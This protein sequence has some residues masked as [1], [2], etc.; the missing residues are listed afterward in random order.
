V[1]TFK[2]VFGSIFNYEGNRAIIFQ[3][4]EQVPINEVKECIKAT[5][6]YHKVKRLPYLVSARKVAKIKIVLF[7]SNVEQTIA[8]YYCDIF[9]V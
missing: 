2:E 7:F 3:V 4:D 1:E 8:G 6:F 9:L 5:L